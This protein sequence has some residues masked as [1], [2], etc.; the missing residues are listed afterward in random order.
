[1][2]H[3]FQLSWREE[4]VWGKRG[5]QIPCVHLKGGGKEIGVEKQAPMRSDDS[6][7]TN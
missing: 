1:M 4:R 5:E 3:A 2:D 6:H 7:I